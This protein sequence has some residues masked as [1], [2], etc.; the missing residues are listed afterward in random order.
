MLATAGVTSAFFYIAF[1]GTSLNLWDTGSVEIGKTIG[2]SSAA[3]EGD[4]KFQSTTAGV[5]ISF[6]GASSAGKKIVLES[7]NDNNISYNDI[8]QRAKDTYD[9]FD[10]NHVPQPNEGATLLVESEEAKRILGEIINEIQLPNIQ[11]GL[12][13]MQKVYKRQEK[14]N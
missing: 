6:G 2:A 3:L 14:N 12:N 7:Y 8:E 11:E 1:D 9:N 13:V 5:A 4:G 10:K